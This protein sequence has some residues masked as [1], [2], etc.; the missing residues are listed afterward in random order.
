MTRRTVGTMFAR[1]RTPGP[2]R[3]VAPERPGTSSPARVQPALKTPTGRA[4]LLR[5]GLVLI[6]VITL[7]LVVP[8]LTPFGAGLVL[9]IV[10]VALYAALFMTLL[11]HKSR[12][13]QAP[14]AWI[15]VGIAVAANV[16]IGIVAATQ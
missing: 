7:L 1:H 2:A 15:T 5:G 10:V 9:V 8:S 6:T 12:R 16:G 11:I 3:I 14:L 13:D 4:W